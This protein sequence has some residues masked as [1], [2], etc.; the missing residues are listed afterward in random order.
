VGDGF[1]GKAG[2]MA[3]TLAFLIGRP[4]LILG[5]A[6]LWT[7]AAV[8]L[9]RCRRALLANAAAWLVYAGWEGLILA[10]T[11][12]ADIRVDLLLIGPL[13]TGLG[14]WTLVAFL[15]RLWR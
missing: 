12:E 14:V 9:P 15:R 2:T 4:H 13:L 1:T 7:L 8:A 5:V 6:A 3:S 11:P 10:I